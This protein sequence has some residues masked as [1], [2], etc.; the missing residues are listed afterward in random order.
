M[1]RHITKSLQDILEDVLVTLE[2]D[3]IKKLNIFSKFMTS[4]T[5]KQM[6]TIHI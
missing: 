6:L 1:V 2:N 4:S 5:G 3:L